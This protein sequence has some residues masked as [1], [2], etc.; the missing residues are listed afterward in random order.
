MTQQISSGVKEVQAQEEQRRESNRATYQRLLKKPRVERE[1]SLNLPSAVGETETVTFKF[2]SLGAQEY[3]KLIDAHPPTTEQ[4]IDGASFNIDTFAPSLISKVC[5]E[6]EMSFEDV[7][8]LWNSPDWN[9]GELMHLF[10]EAMN[11]CNSVQPKIPF[12]ASG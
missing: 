1:V 12:T 2:R 4:K 7:K 10:G 5:L 9:R 3:D 8:D 6:P 11:L